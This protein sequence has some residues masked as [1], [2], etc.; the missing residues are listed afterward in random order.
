MSKE[1]T[2]ISSRQTVQAK[3]ASRP[4]KVT[5]KLKVA[6]NLMIYEAKQ[7]DEAARQA[8]Y[9]VRSMRLALE[10]PHVL[11]YL[12][13]AKEVFRQ[14]LCA[15]NPRRLA[16]LRDQNENRAAA[17][18]AVRALEGLGDEA[19]APGGQQRTP[20]LV[21]VINAAPTPATVPSVIEATPLPCPE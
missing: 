5:G 3:T 20:G 10:R 1:P 16:E 4:G 18:N 2:A 19:V 21:I 13:S 7:W 14:S 15:A 17:V 9:S 8:D 6:I 12:R 11:A